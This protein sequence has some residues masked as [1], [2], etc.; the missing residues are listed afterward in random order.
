MKAHRTG[1]QEKRGEKQQEKS[2]PRAA[3]LWLSY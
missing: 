3:G 2:E 1:T